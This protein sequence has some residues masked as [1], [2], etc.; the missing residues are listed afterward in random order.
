MSRGFHYCASPVCPGYPFRA[1]ALSHPKVTCADGGGADRETAPNPV[2]QQLKAIETAATERPQV[3]NGGGGAN[4]EACDARRN[5]RALTR[6]R[7]AITRAAAQAGH[8]TRGGADGRPCVVDTA[9]V[10]I[11]SALW[12]AVVE[13]CNGE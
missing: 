12:R 9:A 2:V 5:A 6:L 8:P 7:T 3:G 4:D 11:P 1:S 13:A 10:E